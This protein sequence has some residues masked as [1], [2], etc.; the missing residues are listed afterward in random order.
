VSSVATP[1]RAPEHTDEATGRSAPRL[2]EPS[3]VTL[4]DVVLSAW[5]DLA[6]GGPAECP[7]CRG[8]L[9][10]SGGCESCGSELG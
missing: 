2:F 7:V 5:E 6:A 8:R 1:V 10:V 4:E 9:R 3:G